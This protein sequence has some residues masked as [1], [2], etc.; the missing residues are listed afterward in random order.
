MDR[1][2][3]QP[4]SIRALAAH[5]QLSGSRFRQL[6]VEQTG[7]APHRYLKCLRLRRARLLIERTFLTVTEV[8]TLVGYDDAGNFSRDFQAKHDVLPG[9]LRGSGAATP[10]PRPGA[11]GAPREAS[12]L[13]PRQHGRQPQRSAADAIEAAEPDKTPR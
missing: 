10:L 11:A 12:A 9:A 7:A 2:L 13:R 8:M 4:V 5:V 1:R 6:F 3:G